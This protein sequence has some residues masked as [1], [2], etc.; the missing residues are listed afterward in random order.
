LTEKGVELIE[1][2]PGIELQRDVLDGMGFTPVMEKP[3]ALMP[4]AYFTGALH[5]FA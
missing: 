5:G 1:I 2:A 4:A 3:P